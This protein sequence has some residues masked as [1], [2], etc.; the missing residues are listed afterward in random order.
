MKNAVPKIL[1]A[2]SFAA[3][4]LNACSKSNQFVPQST[5]GNAVI[6]PHVYG[7]LPPNADEYSNVPLYSSQASSGLVDMSIAGSEPSVYA[8]ANPPVRNQGQIGSCT[9]F[10]GTEA[11]EILYYYGHGNVF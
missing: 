6:V 10:C 3:A 2:A 1:F 9:S 8:L 7:V 4:I 11:Y 5:D